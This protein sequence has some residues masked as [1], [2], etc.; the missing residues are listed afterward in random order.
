M[1]TSTAY[2]KQTHSNNSNNKSE[3]SLFNVAVIMVL[4]A[5]AAKC[6]AMAHAAASLLLGDQPPKYLLPSWHSVAHPPLT[7][8][9][10]K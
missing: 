1:N 7:A 5:F 3:L 2:S 10:V 4:P 6:C 9:T 8:A